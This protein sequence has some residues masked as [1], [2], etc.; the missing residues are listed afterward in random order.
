[1][2]ERRLQKVHVKDL[3]VGMFVF[4][5]GRHWIHHPW[6]H[7][8]KLITSARDI[9]QLIDYGIREVTVDLAR[10][11]PLIKLK[12]IEEKKEKSEDKELAGKK[13]KRTR[14]RTESVTMA[15]EL[16]RAKKIYFDALETTREFLADTRAGRKLNVAKVRDNVETMIESA[17]RNRDASLALIKL[18]TY[19][20]YTLTHSLNVG[21]LAISM[22]C[23]INL[24]RGKLRQLG[25]GAILH[26]LGKTKVP[27]EILNKKAKL[28]AEE[29]NA[30]KFHPVIGAQMLETT[31][32]ISD[33][34]ISVARYHHER[35]D[36][37][38]YPD[39][40]SGEKISHF[41]IIT[42]M[43]DVY[44]AMSSD[45]VYRKGILPHEALKSLFALRGMQ[46]DSFWI[47]K[48]IQCLGI[49]PDKAS[50]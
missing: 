34:S 30:I 19:D 37:T 13:E 38:G 8:S 4:D 9:D 28:T 27:L 40:L 24:P 49:Y 42:G 29:F 10:G 3:N 31:S 43:S 36:G 45:R 16:P 33:Q 46:F 14:E 20:E 22:G 15:E 39:G 11:L 47:E 18:K 25:M 35:I 6:P 32:N 21:V 17:F 23:H 7:R 41:M 26:D 48:F 12:E 5:V 2:L 44:D 1:M 50:F